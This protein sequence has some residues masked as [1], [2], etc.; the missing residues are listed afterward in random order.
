MRLES[1][2]IAVEPLRT[3]RNAGSSQEHKRVVVGHC[4]GPGAPVWRKLRDFEHLAKVI[5]AV[6]FKDG[7]E[8]TPLVRFVSATHNTI[9][10]IAYGRYPALEVV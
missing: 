2:R 9:R 4:L 3:T 5:A 6:Q 7:I 10:K 8:G 1:A